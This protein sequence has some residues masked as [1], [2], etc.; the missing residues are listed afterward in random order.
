MDLD[1]EKL[2]VD[3]SDGKEIPEEHISYVVDCLNAVDTTDLGRVPSIDAVYAYLV[4]IGKLRRFEHRPILERYLDANDV[5]TVSQVLETLCLDW[6]GTAEYLE[7]V[8]NFA[9][10][11]GWDYD[12]DVRLS[13]IRILGEFIAASGA[14]ASSQR[15]A[16]EIGDS[17]LQ[18]FELLLGVFD[19][20][21]AES[22]TRQQA[23]FSLCRGLGKQWS[24]LPGECVNL[25][26]SAGSEDVDWQLIDQCR[27]L[28]NSSSSESVS[29]DSS[30]SSSKTGPPAIR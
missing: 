23:Y 27:E 4:V 25:D 29:A 10:G 5:L 6:G 30:N 22:W 20:K 16:Q 9:L 13:A 3:I 7:R 26:L 21:D 17:H 12:D 24:E 15:P 11:V 2:L 19:D 28:L 18:V 14:K 1:A 8:F